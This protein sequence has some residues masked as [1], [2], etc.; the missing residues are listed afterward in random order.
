MQDHAR[1]PSARSRERRDRVVLGGARVDDERLAGR[2]RELDLGVER[3]LLVGAR[4]VVAEVVQA[5]LADRAAALVRG[6]RV[7]VGEVGRRRSPRRGWGGG[8]PRRRPPGSRSAAASAL[9]QLA[10]VHADGEDP[11]HA[12]R[13]RPRATSSAF[14]GSHES[15]WVWLSITRRQASVGCLGN[16]GSSSPTAPTGAAPK[17]RAVEREARARRARRAASRRSP[18]MPRV[19]Q[20]RHARAAPRRAC[21]STRRARPRAPRPWPAATARAPRR[22]GSAAARAARSPRAPGVT[23]ARSSSSATRSASPSKSASSAGSTS[24][25]GHR[26]RRGS[27]RPSRSCGW[28]GCRTR[29]PARVS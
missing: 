10:R 3:A 14:G 26:R 6:E 8:R 13:A 12:G 19:Q 18:G 11:A 27:A 24:T 16:S 17:L 20:H 15:R 25:C 2:A 5:R 1:A 22:S 29:W 9:R 4:R 23:S 28:R 7:R 21:A